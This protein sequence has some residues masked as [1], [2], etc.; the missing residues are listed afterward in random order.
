MSLALTAGVMLCVRDQV[1]EEE[2]YLERTYGSEFRRYAAR[3][4][5]FWPGCGM[6]TQWASLS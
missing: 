6:L 5:R 2:V 3:V 4:G 1:L